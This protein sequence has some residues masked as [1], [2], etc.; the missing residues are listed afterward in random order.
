[1]N[2]AFICCHSKPWRK[3]YEL[4]KK[5]SMDVKYWISWENDIKNLPQDKGIYYQS[6]E[7]AW[8]GLGFPQGKVAIDK[9]IIE[10]S[11]Y[12]ELIALKM[13]DRLDLDRYSFNFNERQAHFRSMLGYWL[14]ILDE[15]SLDLIVTPTAPHRVFDFSLYVA[16]KIRNVKFIFYQVTHFDEFGFLVDD[17]EKYPQKLIKELREGS[18][19]GEPLT[20]ITEKVESLLNDGNDAVNQPWY[21]VD[22][23]RDQD[24]VS[25]SKVLF[26]VKKLKKITKALQPIDIYHKEK[27]RPL[28]ESKVSH[29]RR[30]LHKEAQYIRLKKLKEYYE[31]LCTD[32]APK[33]YVLV[34]LH[35]QPEET[36]CPNGGVYVD[37]LLVIEL[38]SKCL[39]DDCTVLVK[40]HPMQFYRNLE[41]GASRDKQF[42][43]YAKSI[44]K[45]K[46][47]STNSNQ[48]EL[49]RNA[50]G[51]AT[52]T[53]TIG[54]EAAVKGKK[55]YLFGRSWYMGMP[56]VHSIRTKSDLTTAVTSDV[57]VS[58]CAIKNYHT[59][60]SKVMINAPFYKTWGIESRECEYKS[61]QVIYQSILDFIS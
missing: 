46:F 48:F 44:D 18:L 54:W 22:S 29:L 24:K 37:Q 49:L 8:Q 2:L 7:N 5:N 14:H 16:C 43:D 51:V 42:Y 41:G 56:N 4:M 15:Y 27:G 11:S 12:Y 34:A 6:V 17:I 61:S 36:T 26:Y 25:S 19:E 53:G 59:R 9:E 1:M 60:L 30:F 13:M 21:M 40:E 47:I 38:L 45:V 39:P 31:S 20:E 32:I 33:K 3:V 57:D 10:K 23:K 50:E 55:V 58:S 35:Y 28:S 52:V